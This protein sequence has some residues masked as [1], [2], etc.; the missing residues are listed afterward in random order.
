VKVSSAE[1]AR[2]DI[3]GTSPYVKE[4]FRDWSSRWL[5]TGVDDIWGDVHF[6]H[7]IAGREWGCA[8]DNWNS[9]SYSDRGQPDMTCN[10]VTTCV[11][12]QVITDIIRVG[13]VLC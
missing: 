7:V 9:W 2:R 12:A 3:D 5:S 4:S 10:A 8:F 6:K 11:L 13:Y 1:L